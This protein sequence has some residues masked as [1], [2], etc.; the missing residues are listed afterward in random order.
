MFV[1]AVPIYFLL[2]FPLVFVLVNDFL[3]SGF[4][5][6]LLFLVHFGN[7]YDLIFVVVSFF[8]LYAFA[9]CVYGRVY[10]HCEICQ[11]LFH[12]CF[13]YPHK[14]FLEEIT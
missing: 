14:G 6:F 9:C 10:N 3:F 1:F 7:A 12:G 4:S 5:L 8:L 11:M 2:F 13:T